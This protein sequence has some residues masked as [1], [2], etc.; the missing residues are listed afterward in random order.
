MGISK[1]MMEKIA[2]QKSRIT[3]KT[4]INITRYGNV[5]G[6]RGSVIPMFVNQIMSNQSIT[7]TDPDM[8]RFMMSLE[9]AVDLVLYAFK[10]GKAGEIF[11]QKSP[12]VNIKTLANALKE[13]L[14]TSK[15]KT[16]IIGTRHGEK[17]YEVLLS[18]EEMARAQE[19]KYYYCI[20][21]DIRD[22]NYE[23][24]IDKGEKKISKSR[25]YNSN[26]TVSLNIKKMKKLLLKQDFIKSTIKKKL[27]T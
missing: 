22:L 5:M 7:I 2:I 15:H 13:I 27:K 18:R 3:N 4:V 6:S 11:V 10:H 14:N 23:K 26:N 16:N 24:F 17:L 9:D 19:S 1:A 21:P 12:A 25:E 8:T 20:Y